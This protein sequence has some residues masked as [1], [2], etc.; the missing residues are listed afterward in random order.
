M[1]H[2]HGV[3]RVPQVF[4]R[5]E[6]PADPLRLRPIPGAHGQQHL[7]RQRRRDAHATAGEA[8]EAEAAH[9]GDGGLFADA[10]HDERRR[11]EAD[12]LLEEGVLRRIGADDGVLDPR[13]QAVGY[14]PRDLL[15]RHVAL[16]LHV[17][18]D[19]LAELLREA[20]QSG[21]DPGEGVQALVRQDHHRREREVP[22]HL[23]LVHHHAVGRP[24]GGHHQ[25]VLRGRS[26]EHR[27]H[28][29]VFAGTD[30]VEDRVAAV[31]QRVHAA[32][33]DVAD[34]PGVLGGG[35]APFGIAGERR[36]GDDGSG[37]TGG[38]DGA[39]VH[40]FRRCRARASADRG[41][42]SGSRSLRRPV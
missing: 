36:H 27:Q 23:G 18:D 25:G 32:G 6:D 8:R 26:G 5:S 41:G 3:D 11:H 20:P 9:M 4:Q 28:A 39:C 15:R 16:L 31:E 22:Q 38:G 42:G 35:D 37:E 30:V 17:D 40:R 10:A 24:R 33:L 13:H 14:Q 7:L 34:D 2:A 29:G 21:L 12:Q 1:Q 19:R